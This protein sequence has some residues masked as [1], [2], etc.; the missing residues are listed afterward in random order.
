MRLKWVL[1]VSYTLNENPE[2]VFEL[3]I[4]ALFVNGVSYYLIENIKIILHRQ[5]KRSFGCCGVKRKAA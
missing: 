2:T 4:Q 1:N 3:V 5:G